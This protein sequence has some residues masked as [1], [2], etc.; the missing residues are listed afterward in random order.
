MSK[1]IADLI[2]ERAQRAEPVRPERVYLASVGEGQKYVVEAQQLSA[3]QDN[4]VI[5]EAKELAAEAQRPQ[6]AGSKGSEELRKIRE[7]LTDVRARLAELAD[8]MREYEGELTIRAT[9]T[10]GEWEQWRI[11]HPARDEDHPGFRDDATLTGLACNLDDL[12]ADLG[13]YVVAWNGEPLPAGGY[14]A[15]ELLRP[16]KKA[17][18]QIVVGM[19]ETGDDLPKWRSALSAYLERETSSDSPSE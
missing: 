16:D 7:R 15:L 12:L 8:L 5:A 1:S 17:I 4:L 9:K 13:T 2:A 18:A 19:Y 14:D 10:D 3:E 6:K 11:A